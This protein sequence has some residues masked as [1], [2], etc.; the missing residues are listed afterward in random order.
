MVAG[1]VEGSSPAGPSHLAGR[2][3]PASRARSSSALAAQTEE[4]GEGSGEE[5]SPQSAGGSARH[6]SKPMS[7]PERGQCHGGGRR[8]HSSGDLWGMHQVLPAQPLSQ[9]VGFCVLEGL[10]LLGVNHIGICSHCLERYSC[11][12]AAVGHC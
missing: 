5:E 2:L 9:R 7:I 12:T 11:S 8:L 3:I 4:E 10:C 1:G 6:A